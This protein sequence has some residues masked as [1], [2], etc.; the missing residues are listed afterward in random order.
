MPKLEDYYTAYSAAQYIG[1]EYKTLLQR[2]SRGKVNHE[3]LGA[4]VIIIHKDEVERVK[5]EH[6]AS[7]KQETQS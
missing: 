4:R 5:R 7:P 1:L 6:E 2:C 3:R